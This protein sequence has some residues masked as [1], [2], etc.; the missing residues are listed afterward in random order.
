ME[1]EGTGHH[2]TAREISGQPPL[3]QETYDTLVSQC[4]ALNHFLQP[5]W[6][7]PHLNIVLTGAGTSA[8]IGEALRGAFLKNTGK[9]TR[10]VATTDLVSHP[11]LFFTAALP[12]LLISFARSGNSPESV[13]AVELA[14]AVGGKVYH[15]VITCNPLGKL[16]RQQHGPQ[17][18]VILLPSA[19]NDQG[20]AMT[21][22]YSAMLLTGLLV[23]RLGSLDEIRPQLQT[24]VTYGTCLLNNAPAS[25]QKV[26]DLPFKRVVFLGSGPL[27]GTAQESN[28]KV[29]ELTDGRVVGKHDSFLG[30]R[31]GPKVVADAHTLLVFLFSNDPYVQQYEIDLA[32]EFHRGA[33]AL[34]TIGVSEHVV[35]GVEVDIQIAMSEEDTTIDEEFLPI[36]SV[37]PAQML[38]YYKSLQLGFDPDKPSAN[39]TIS[40][41]VQGVNIYPYPK[42]P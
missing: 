36:C 41:V 16:A 31:H 12:T 5:I 15:L 24:L 14:N 17:G 8:F 1:G 40:R 38:G 7:E 6:A 9:L 33:G 13:A 10:A 21:G 27:L 19:A 28:L 30:F 32:R 29:Q 39:G 3:W 2:Y 26:A 25:L 22:S 37:L 34:Y 4:S 35:P 42:Q 23:S 20:L 18:Y 11:A